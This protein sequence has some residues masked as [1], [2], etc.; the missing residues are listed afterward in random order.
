MKKDWEY[1]IEFFAH[2]EGSNARARKDEEDL[3]K[4]KFEHSLN[5]LGKE[6][7]ELVN[8]HYSQTTRS[9]EFT[10]IFKKEISI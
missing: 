4:E 9:R 5:K 10:C 6:G 3:Y 2:N 8:S 7:W 1:K